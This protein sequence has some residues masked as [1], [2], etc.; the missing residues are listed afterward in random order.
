MNLDD[1]KR[2]RP[3]DQ[4]DVDRQKLRLIHQRSQ[5]LPFTCTED[6]QEWPCETVRNL[7]R[8]RPKYLTRNEE[9]IGEG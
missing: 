4:Y 9:E 3:V 6:G 8:T 7:R 5:T 1:L 2:D